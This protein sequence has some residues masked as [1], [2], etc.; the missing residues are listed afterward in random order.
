M[1]DPIT[2]YLRDASA[3]TRQAQR[4]ELLANVQYLA[5]LVARGSRGHPA[6]AGVALPKGDGPW[7]R[8]TKKG[9]S[10]AQ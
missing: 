9:H 5:R 1:P 7:T 4:R 10:H 8:P 6:I 2:A 3:A